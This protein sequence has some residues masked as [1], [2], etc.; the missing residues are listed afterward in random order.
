M[1]IFKSPVLSQVLWNF[2][3]SMSEANAFIIILG[4]KPAEAGGA[5]LGAP[6]NLCEGDTRIHR[7]PLK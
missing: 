3:T 1:K 7:N 6:L 2:D 4:E 5:P